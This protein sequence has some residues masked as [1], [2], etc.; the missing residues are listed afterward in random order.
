MSSNFQAE[1]PP[2][3]TKKED[4]AYQNNAFDH[5]PSSNDTNVQLR[6][7]K[8][9]VSTSTLTTIGQDDT[10]DKPG[11]PP[12][13]LYESYIL[14]C[15]AE[16]VGTT[17][18]LFTI[19]MVSAYGGAAGPTWLLGVSLTTGFAFFAL[20]IS[21]GPVSGAH[22][23][24]VVTMAITLAGDCNPILGIPYVIAQIAGAI[25]GAYFTK[26]IVPS[27][28][29]AQCLG[30]AHS[31][32]PGVTAGGAILCEVLITAFLVLVILMSGVDTINKQNPLPPL[33]VG[34]AV[35]VGI[36]CGG[37]FS[38]GSMNPARAFG[39]AVA[40]GVWDHHYVWWVG[41]I[42]GGLV[43]TGIYRML[44]A[45]EDRRVLLWRRTQKKDT[46]MQS[47]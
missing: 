38:G 18:F 15:I 17:L 31:V 44:M 37:P 43:S 28:T 14:P 33:A 19:C 30:G 47:T 36:T 8:Q 26:F 22:L 16:Y 41:P 27:T 4:F 13:H 11:D 6:C 12:L 23:N 1:H 39:P 40:S 9:S 24:P 5:T 7:L 45:S 3:P 32:G 34:L 42:L 29:Y 20:C 25:T 21:I 10:P 2:Q 46:R 35:V